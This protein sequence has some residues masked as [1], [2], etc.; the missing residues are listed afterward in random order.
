MRHTL[1]GVLA[2]LLAG[3]LASLPAMAAPNRA[4]GFVLQAQGAQLDG[5]PAVNGT[6]LFA[7]DVLGTNPRG[8]LRM[9]IAG[10]QFYLLGSSAATL[11]EETSTAIASLTTGTAGFVSTQRTAV[12]I[13]ALDVI[14]RPKAAVETRAQV[15]VNGPAE[16]LVQS[17]H[18]ALELELDGRVYHMPSGTSYRVQVQ[19]QDQVPQSMDAKNHPPMNQRKLIFLV[20][21]GVGALAGGVYIYTELNES[22][23]TP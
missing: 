20:F 3:S 11:T 6:N 10:N 13:R 7:G 8:T 14:V 17:F 18:G 12:Q 23:D 22:P 5:S 1:R 4:M 2:G 19:S 9:Q 16:L 15:T 21:A